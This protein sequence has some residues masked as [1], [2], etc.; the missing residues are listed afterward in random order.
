MK[1]F[2]TVASLF[3]LT[4]TAAAQDADTQAKVDEGIRSIKKK[5]F[6]FKLE[7]RFFAPNLNAQLKTADFRHNGGRVD[8]RDDLN[9]TRNNAPEII[10]RCKNFSVDWLHLHGAGRSFVG[11][12]LNFGGQNFR[13]NLNSRSDLDFVKLKFDKE[14]FSLMGTG[15]E[16]NVALNALS[17]R[18]RTST[19][20][21]SATKKFF[22]VLPSVGINFYMRIRP[23]LDIYAQISWLPLGRRGH[24]EDFESG[25]KYFPRENFSVSAGW[26]RIGWKFHRGGDLSKFTLNGPFVGL[27][28]DF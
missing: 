14:I 3:L 23:R 4:T 21:S 22:G 27:R 19:E 7:T 18:G 26:R 9:F 28:Y 17:W 11:G 15:L 8:L 6:D 10:L 1:T 13:G 12:T 25:L 16:W 24:F 20:N 2:L 5:T